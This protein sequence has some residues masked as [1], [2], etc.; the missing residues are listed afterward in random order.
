L[1]PQYTLSTNISSPS[2]VH[3]YALFTIPAIKKNGLIETVERS[4]QALYM[5]MNGKDMDALHQRFF[6][7]GIGDRL[8]DSSLQPDKLRGVPVSMWTDGEGVSTILSEEFAMERAP[9]RGKMYTTTWLGPVHITQVDREG[10]PLFDTLIRKNQ[11]VGNYFYPEEIVNR[12]HDKYLFRDLPGQQ[13]YNQLISVCTYKAGPSI[14]ILLNDAP[15]NFESLSRKRVNVDNPFAADAIC[16]RFSAG[17]QLEKWH[18][19]GAPEPAENR[20]C[21]LE[22]GHF[23]AV[24]KQYAAL[25]YHHDGREKDLRLAWCKLP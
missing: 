24:R 14:Y 4:Y 8:I 12:P 18:L 11:A 20:A 17:R 23:D 1:V 2:L 13:V 19:F 16:Y 10:I 22:S 15:E 9:E 25:V 7:S 21:F 6:L 3:Q 5:L